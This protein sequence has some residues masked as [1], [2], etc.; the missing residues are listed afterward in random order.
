MQTVI[1]LFNLKPGVDRAEYEAWARGS[2]LPVVND[3]ASV[4]KFE[5]LKASG[6]LIG[7]G[8]APYEYIE[9]MRIRDMEAFGKDLGSPAVQSGAAQFQQY[10]DQPLFILASNL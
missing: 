8:P 5:V 2:D 10:A 7:D 4:D 9:I 1:V 6:L 3:L